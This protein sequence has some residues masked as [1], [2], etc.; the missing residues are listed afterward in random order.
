L[1]GGAF[2]GLLWWLFWLLNPELWRHLD[3]V[4]GYIIF[5]AIFLGW[6]LVHGCLF[7]VV[8]PFRGKDPMRF[9]VSYRMRRAVWLFALPLL[10]A[11][12]TAIALAV[13]MAQPGLGWQW[14]PVLACVIL[15]MTLLG[16]AWL[17]QECCDWIQPAL[18]RE[19]GAV[20]TAGAIIV[21]SLSLGTIFVTCTPYVWELIMPRGNI[22]VMAAAEDFLENELELYSVMMIG[23][24][25]HG[26][27]LATIVPVC[28]AVW[29]V[30]PPRRR[31]LGGKPWFLFML[32]V[33]AAF[34]L[35]AV[36]IWMF[37]G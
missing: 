10:T 3:E 24:A 35:L 11:W 1:A 28:E 9:G 21:L 27:L 19:L 32:P 29:K 25:V 4:E 5:G 34:D 2:G 16:T 14:E 8:P 26:G 12:A 37:V 20:V 30:P 23:P 33:L 13:F 31:D 6:G 17:A 18:P 7:L 15:A 22:T 36:T